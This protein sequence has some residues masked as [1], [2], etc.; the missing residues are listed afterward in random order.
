MGAF[1]GVTSDH[2]QWSL[3]DHQLPQIP[4]EKHKVPLEA[5]LDLE[6][7]TQTMHT[8]VIELLHQLSRNLSLLFFF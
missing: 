7:T 4:Q 8:V 2:Q 3:S 1:L 6:L 5:L